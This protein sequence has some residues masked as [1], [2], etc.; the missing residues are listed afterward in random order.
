MA[1][2]RA[3]Y[4]DDHPDIK[5]LKDTIAGLE[6]LKKDL[7]AEA[8]EN[9]ETNSATPAQISQLTPLMQ[10][11]SQL[12]ANKQEIQTKEAE[13][14]RL[15]Q[16]GQEYS[17]RM[18]QTPAVE[19]EM[20]DMMR[21][22]AQSKR[23]YADLLAKKQESAL[24]TNL[25]RQQQGEQFRIIDPPSLARQAFV[26]GPLQVLAGC[27]RRG[28]DSGGGVWSWIRVPRRSYS[29]RGRPW[30]R[31]LR[32]RCWWRFQRYPPRPRFER[33]AGDLGLP[34]PPLSLVVVLIP[35]GVA[36]AYFWG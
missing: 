23:D 21:D 24:A 5:K 16:A 18:G 2:L 31:L 10:V 32:C 22:Y 34:P 25:Q 12:K 4:T 13:I 9:L 17:R 28:I 6:K 1:D 14:Q 35:T 36:Y 19:A 29:H 3:R 26:P 11:Q 20:G 33:H 7:G 8:K 27:G 30:P 15:Q